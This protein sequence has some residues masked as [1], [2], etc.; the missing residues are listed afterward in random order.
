[1]A[2]GHIGRVIAI[3]RP[4]AVRRRALEH[5]R[6]RLR[7]VKMP[8]LAARSDFIRRRR[9]NGVNPEEAA[10]PPL[11]APRR[12]ASRPG[13]GSCHYI[14]NT[15]YMTSLLLHLPYSTAPLPP[16]P[17]V[18]HTFSRLIWKPL[19]GRRRPCRCFSH[20][21][22]LLFSSCGSRGWRWLER[23]GWR[24]R[25]C[26]PLLLSSWRRQG[27]VNGGPTLNN[28]SQDNPP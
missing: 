8:T 13:R 25:R 12:V 1:M 28:C 27:N 23:R 22:S 6:R 3:V 20:D 19:S 26:C 11:A 18:I 10:A 5:S 7:A 15:S 16:H 21:T 14:L 4:V 9:G 17:S 24:Q 2:V